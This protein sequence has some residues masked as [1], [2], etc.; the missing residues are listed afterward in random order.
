MLYMLYGIRR[1]DSG[2]ILKGFCATKQ[3]KDNEVAWNCSVW[4]RWQN[5]IKS[6]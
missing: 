3:G 5:R 6:L 2:H 4:Q 1:S